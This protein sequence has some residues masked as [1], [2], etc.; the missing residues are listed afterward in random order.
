MEKE[1]LKGH[2]PVLVLGI[3]SERSLHGYAICQLVKDRCAP[4]LRLGEGTLYP[5]L[6][7][8]EKK[9][10]IQA[11]W[12]STPNGKERKVYHLTDAGNAEIQKHKSE[13]S[14]LQKL[15]GE[16]LGPSWAKA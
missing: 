1:L 6:R 4:A 5:L 14:Q 3:L 2:L 15:Y 16:L 7:R 11:V 8:L 13:W 10:Q 9:G 12:E